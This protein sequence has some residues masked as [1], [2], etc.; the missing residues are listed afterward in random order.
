MHIC[1]ICEPQSNLLKI[2]MGKL[3]ALERVSVDLTLNLEIFNSKV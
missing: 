2:D 1:K 3:K